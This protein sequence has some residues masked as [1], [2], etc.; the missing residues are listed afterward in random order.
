MTAR[1]APSPEEAIEQAMQR[2]ADEL[3]LVAIE[4]A[5]RM[6]DETILSA[7]GGRNRLMAHCATLL[8][9]AYVDLVQRYSGVEPRRLRDVVLEGVGKFAPVLAPGGRT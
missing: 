4:H 5:S 6:T 3:A 2:A 8:A 9:Y 1:V 7:P